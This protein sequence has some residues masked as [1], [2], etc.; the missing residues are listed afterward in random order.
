MMHDLMF[1]WKPRIRRD[2]H[3]GALNTRFVH[4]GRRRKL[5]CRKSHQEIPNMDKCPAVFT[6]RKRKR[7][8]L[9]L[10]LRQYMVYLSF[11]SHLQ[12]INIEYE[13]CSAN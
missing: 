8:S 11:S 12:V 1:Y 2:E 5:S 13:Q 10:R 3:H 4:T 7:T 9:E 6:E